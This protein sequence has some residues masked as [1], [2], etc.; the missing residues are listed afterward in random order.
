MP[1]IQGGKFNAALHSGQAGREE[2]VF[3][4]ALQLC[5][6]SVAY[7]LADSFQSVFSDLG[8]DGFRDMVHRKHRGG[9]Q[10]QDNRENGQG[11]L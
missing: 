8:D 7:S 9:K 3:A 11:Q 4:G 5:N 6:Q 1:G 10:K 2:H